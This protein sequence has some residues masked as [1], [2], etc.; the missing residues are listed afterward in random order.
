L[1]YRI[2]EKYWEE[3]KHLEEIRQ[4]AQRIVIPLT[5]DDS[6]EDEDEDLETDDDEDPDDNMDDSMFPEVEYGGDI[7]VPEC[8]IDLRGPQFANENE[9]EGEMRNPPKKRGKQSRAS[10]KKI[11]KKLF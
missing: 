3:D 8:S 7:V 11:C 1:Y 6:D 9:L 2:Q 4:P 10:A 5:T